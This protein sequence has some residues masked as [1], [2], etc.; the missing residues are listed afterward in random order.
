MT[1]NIRINALHS[2]DLQTKK[3]SHVH[4]HAFIHTRTL[5]YAFNSIRPVISPTEPNIDFQ[6]ALTI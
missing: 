5:R 3:L 6:V 1:Y 4:N 2:F